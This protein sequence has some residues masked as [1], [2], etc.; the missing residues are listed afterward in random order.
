MATR[1]KQHKKKKKVVVR[2][3][4]RARQRRAAAPVGLPASRVLENNQF[5]QL[6]ARLAGMEGRQYQMNRELPNSR[7]QDFYVSQKMQNGVFEQGFKDMMSRQ[8]ELLAK[9]TDA[10]QQFGD[11]KEWA[12]EANDR[13][14]D[15]EREAAA[16]V[17]S[18]FAEAAASGAARAAARGD[19]VGGASPLNRQPPP[20]PSPQEADRLRTQSKGGSAKKRLGFEQPPPPRAPRQVTPGGTEQ[21]RKQ[22]PRQGGG[23]AATPKPLGGRGGRGGRGGGR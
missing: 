23:G 22:R 4:R 7:E 20:L 3:V 1:K 21:K 15:R 18:D 13:L 19:L 12:R 17:N 9:Q 6:D 14:N 8:D 11:L 2:R 10:D 5:R 16:G